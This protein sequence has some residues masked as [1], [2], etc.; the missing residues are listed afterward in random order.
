MGRKELRGPDRRRRS[1]VGESRNEYTDLIIS[2]PREGRK[3]IGIIS[4]GSH[5]P[6][7]SRAR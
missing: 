2:E 4:L 5:L 7:A 6:P 3:I 1:L